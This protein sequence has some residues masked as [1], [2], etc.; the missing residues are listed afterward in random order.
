MVLTKY[1]VCINGETLPFLTTGRVV[2]S[3]N[4]FTDI[5]EILL[6]NRIN[7]RGKRISDLIPKGGT[8]KISIGYY[9]NVR[10]IFEGCISEVIPEKTCIIR[11]ENEAYRYKRQ[12]IGKDVILKA[13][14]VKKL[15][16]TIIAEF[17]S[18]LKLTYKVGSINIGDW[19]VTKT[20]TLLDVLAELRDKFR[21]Y[22]Y[23][24]GETLVIGPEADSFNFEEKIAKFENGNVPLGESNFNFKEASSDNTVVQATAI[25]RSGQITEV[26]CYYNSKNEIVFGDVAP[27]S[28]QI[29]EF[30]INGQSDFS[31]SDLKELAK[32]RLEALSF[33][34]VDG[35]ITTYAPISGR[36]N[37]HGDNLKV[38]TKEVPEKNGIYKIV[39]VEYTF[40]VGIGIR[41]KNGLGI[42]IL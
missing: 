14:T 5:A 1:E 24:R 35:S 19:K 2:T 8:I 27:T 38:E 6:P 11:A 29:S 18:E 31:K 22:C 7:S 23:F 21:L 3:R 41:Q 12:S 42:R 39:E 26:F 10:T 13:T 36:F 4:V 34:G 33:T 20:S 16:D 32:R 25:N 15:L 40:G 17:P 9:P 28:G 30:S 37:T